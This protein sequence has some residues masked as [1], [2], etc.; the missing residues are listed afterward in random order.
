MN[1]SLL[2]MIAVLLLITSL[3]SGCILAVEDDAYRRGNVPH[4][5]HRDDGDRRGDYRGER[6]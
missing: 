4:R 3:L 2:A 1:K 6:H 5:D